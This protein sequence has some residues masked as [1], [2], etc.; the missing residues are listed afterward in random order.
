MRK[1]IGEGVSL[2]LGNSH[3]T[4]HLVENTALAREYFDLMGIMVKI[5]DLDRKVTFANR[6]CCEVLECRESDIIGKE[7]TETFV[8]ERIRSKLVRYFH[9]LISGQIKPIEFHINPVVTAKGDERIIGWHNTL[10]RDENGN[11]RAVL[12]SGIDLTAGKRAEARLRKYAERLK[13]LQHF[14]KAILAARSPRVIAEAGLESI[15]GLI[16]ALLGVVVELDFE[17][18]RAE[19]LAT[20]SGCKGRMKAGFTMRLQAPESAGRLKTAEIVSFEQYQPLVEPPVIEEFFRSAGLPACIRVPLLVQDDLIG[21][22]YLS[23]GLLPELGDEQIEIACEF[24]NSMAIGIHNV[25]L[26]QSVVKQREQIRSMAKRIQEVE[27]KQRRELARELHDQ[28]GQRLTALS[29]NLNLIGSQLPREYRKEISSRIDDSVR[30]VEETTKHI[31]EVMCELR[32]PVLDDYGLSAALSWFGEKFSERTGLKLDTRVNE[33]EPRL[34]ISLE[35]VLLRIAQE[36]LNNV[37]KH[38]EAEHVEILFESTPDQVVL[39]VRDDGMGFDARSLQ[40]PKGTTGWG[41]ITMRERA[42]AVGAE[43][44]VGSEVGKGTEVTVVITR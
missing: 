31:R 28:V 2:D 7:W 9:E 37:A 15:S 44:F 5:V 42:A 40:M 32:P 17:R 23:S 8:P 24:A 10:L 39:T 16:P 14:H 33:I 38:A 19:V 13:N 18:E 22:L 25:R 43:L 4:I 35:M 12:S 26:F 29:I 1:C 3:S 21:T 27:E 6:K 30:L 34:P 11:I 41:L 36:A 20:S